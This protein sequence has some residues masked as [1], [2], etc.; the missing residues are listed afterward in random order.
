MTAY[1]FDRQS[2]RHRS[3]R[4][5]C[6][7]RS[8]IR[9][10]DLCLWRPVYLDHLLAHYT[11]RV[12]WLVLLYHDQPLAHRVIVQHESCS[13]RPSP[14]VRGPSVP[15]AV[16]NVRLKTATGSYTA[17]GATPSISRSFRG[18]YERPIRQCRRQAFAYKS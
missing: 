16:P 4:R 6:Q 15:S 17:C 2:V 11:L 8:R 10:R 3:C 12:W 14:C 9:L 18:S 1:A 13:G 5:R 7:H